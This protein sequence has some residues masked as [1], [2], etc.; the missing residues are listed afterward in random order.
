MS[1]SKPLKKSEKKQK[2]AKETVQAVGKKKREATQSH[3]QQIVES[4][5]ENS[6]VEKVEMVCSEVRDRT[7]QGDFIN[8][9]NN[10]EGLKAQ[11][12]VKAFASY[13]KKDKEFVKIIAECLVKNSVDVFYDEWDIQGGDSIP[14]KLEQGINE[15]SIFLYVLSPSSVES[16]W[17]QQEYHSFLWRKLNNHV[18]RIIPILYKD[19]IAPPFIAPLR[20][21]DFRNFSL[22]DPEHRNPIHEGPL[23]ELINSI[24]RRYSKPSI[25][26]IHPAMAS[27]E[28]YYQH[29]DTPT[30]SDGSKYFEFGFKNLTHSPLINFTFTI[31]FNGAVES[32]RYDFERSTANMFGGKGLVDNG[33]TFNWFGNQIME[34]EG[35]IVFTIK[36]RNVPHIK[37]ISTK[38]VGRIAGSNEIIKP[39]PEGLKV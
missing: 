12:Q 4:Y 19:C 9:L 13:Q 10:H 15:S 26:T 34:D 16:K 1:S 5:L 36:S 7:T 2:N 20:Y 30:K 8:R 32:V 14:S 37:K 23:Q 18:L 28:F 25:G 29:K 11:G 22:S 38:L 31:R 21:I 17:V 27:Y 6:Q 3:S 33:K 35:W 39:D 24:F